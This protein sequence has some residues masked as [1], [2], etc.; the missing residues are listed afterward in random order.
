MVPTRRSIMFL[1]EIIRV[2]QLNKTSSLK[3]LQTFQAI[4]SES[5]IAPKTLKNLN[6]AIIVAIQ[7]KVDHTQLPKYI[8]LMVHK[9][10]QLAQVLEQVLVAIMEVQDEYIIDTNDKCKQ[11]KKL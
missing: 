4:I 11:L 10:H 7:Q 8:M 2:K 6:R 5:M 3:F 1:E 9:L